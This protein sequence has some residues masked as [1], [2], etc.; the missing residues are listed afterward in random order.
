MDTDTPSFDADFRKRFA[1]LLAWRRDVRR[2]RTDPLDEAL[3]LHLLTLA[4]RAPSVGLS[5]PWRYVLIE[6]SKARAAV[7][8]SFRRANAAALDG[9]AGDKAQLYAGLKLSGLV[10]VVRLF[11]PFERLI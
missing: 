9:Y 7:R 5:E 1:D 6:S 10:C 11:G 4:N 8:E 3:V 2:F